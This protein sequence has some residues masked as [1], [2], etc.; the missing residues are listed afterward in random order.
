MIRFDMIRNKNNLITVG[1]KKF[2]TELCRQID[3]GIVSS[4]FK[5][6]P[7]I[8]IEIYDKPILRK[9]AEILEIGEDLIKVKAKTIFVR[10]HVEN[11]KKLERKFVFEDKFSGDQLTLLKSGN[12]IVDKKGSF[13]NQLTENINRAISE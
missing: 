7:K 12:D 8:S 13:L 2:Q 3:K 10:S 9:L 4:P 11:N 1:S 6:T 5:E